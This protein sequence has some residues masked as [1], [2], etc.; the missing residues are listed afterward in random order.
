MLLIGHIKRGLGIDCCTDVEVTGDF[1]TA[2]VDGV[3][4]GEA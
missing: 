3:M 4:Q 1:E 2:N